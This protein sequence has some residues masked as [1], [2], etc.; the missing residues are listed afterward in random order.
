MPFDTYL[1]IIQNM[2]SSFSV[3]PTTSTYENSTYGIRVQYPSDWSVGGTNGS[4][5]V[6]A[7]FFSPIG[8]NNAATVA[9]GTETLNNITTLDNYALSTAIK[10]YQKIIL[11]FT[12]L[13]YLN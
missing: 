13:N 6:F 3:I 4:T 7:N 9:L 10:D 1:P 8:S 12:L 5:S 11:I 2:V